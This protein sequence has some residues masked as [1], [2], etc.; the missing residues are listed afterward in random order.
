MIRPAYTV[1]FDIAY[2]LLACKVVSNLILRSCALVV[3]FVGDRFSLIIA[4]VGTVE[5]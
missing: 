5:V 1:K 3:G 4:V 2:C